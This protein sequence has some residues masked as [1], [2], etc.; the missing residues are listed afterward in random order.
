MTPAEAIRS[1]QAE[2]LA[3]ALAA[4]KAMKPGEWYTASAMFGRGHASTL[5]YLVGLLMERGLIERRVSDTIARCWEYR[6][7]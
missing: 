2:L 4:H 7:L 3:R 1:R 5:G 6:R